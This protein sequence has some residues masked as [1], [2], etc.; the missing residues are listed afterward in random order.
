[1]WATIVVVTLP[2]CHQ[3]KPSTDQSQEAGSFQ[4][5][6]RWNTEDDRR[7]DHGDPRSNAALGRWH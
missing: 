7:N 1:M 2:V 4:T 6:S 3:A 5:G